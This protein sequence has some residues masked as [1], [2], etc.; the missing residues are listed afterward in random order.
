M[1]KLQIQVE[2]SG[3]RLHHAD[4]FGHG[5]LADSVTRYHRDAL[6]AHGVSSWPQCNLGARTT[7]NTPTAVSPVPMR[8]VV[9]IGS[10]NSAQ[11]MTAAQGGT[12]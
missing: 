7:K 8:V 6:L 5:F 12:R 3:S 10:S 1:I 2:L 4:T 11:A 9:V